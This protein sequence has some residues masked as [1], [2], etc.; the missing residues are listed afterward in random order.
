MRERAATMRPMKLWRDDMAVLRLLGVALLLLGL[1]WTFL[2]L[3]TLREGVALR[4]A[5]A[6][7]EIS[8]APPTRGR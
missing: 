3:A 2:P 1:L 4:E 7:T 5:A 8:I 6:R